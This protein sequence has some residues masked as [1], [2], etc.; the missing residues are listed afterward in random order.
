LTLVQKVVLTI[1]GIATIV[2][3]ILLLVYNERIFAAL[4]PFAKKWRDMTGGWLILWAATFVVSFPPLIGYSSCVTLSGFVYGFPYG[5]F[6][7]ASATIV[8]STCSFLASRYFLQS[9]VDRLVKNDSRFAALALTLKHDGIK[10]LIMIRL[11]PLP[12]SFSNG[13]I[14]TIPTV[15]WQSFMFATAIVSPKLL[16]H[17]F[18]GAKLGE[19]AERGAEMDAKTKAISYIS[20]I[21]GLVAGAVTGWVI[22]R[23][24]K[25][26]AAELEE[27]EREHAHHT[28]REGIRAEYADDPAALEAA[29]VLREEE[30]DI[31]LRD[32]WDDDYGS[33]DEDEQEIGDG[34][35]SPYHDD[36][37]GDEDA[38]EV[39]GDVLDGDGQSPKR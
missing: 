33:Y 23:Q 32:A 22:Y 13:A 28:S 10:L 25:K 38:R 16:L 21:I 1:A 11:C 35:V 31:S 18:V 4:E 37:S 20:I 5:W 36:G 19:L 2:L 24:T 8:G 14:S 15:T 34:A 26:R 39:S 12:Y 6:I 29:E 7:V 17:V 27:Q 3:G 30:D 9:Y